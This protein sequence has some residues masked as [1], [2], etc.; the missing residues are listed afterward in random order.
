MNI[1]RCFPSKSVKNEDIYLRVSG[2][3]LWPSK[4][5]RRE[6]ESTAATFSPDPICRE[7]TQIARLNVSS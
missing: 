7:Q 2:L 6:L 1:E 4:S 5:Q 3:K